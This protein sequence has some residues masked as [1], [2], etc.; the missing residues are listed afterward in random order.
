MNSPNPKTTAYRNAGHALAPLT[1][2]CL[3]LVLVSCNTLWPRNSPTYDPS[4]AVQTAM[5]K[6]SLADSIAQVRSE[7]QNH[8]LHVDMIER[9]IQPYQT[10]A[11]PTD[12][13]TYGLAHNEFGAFPVRAK[14]LGPHA[15]GYRIVLDVG[16]LTN[17]RFN[18]AKIVIRWQLPIPSEQD[19]AS[20]RWSERQNSFKMREFDV[21]DDF[22]PGRY[23][24]VELNLVPA[25]PEEVRRITVGI[26]FSQ[27]RLLE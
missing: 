14:V 27:I 20:N 3:L 2:L 15:D 4:T 12:G 22:P 7:L 26:K 13:S 21:T 19:T 10:I 9:A 1:L 11:I 6:T 18:G 5:L 8:N 17:G 24:H 23:T 25:K 16:N